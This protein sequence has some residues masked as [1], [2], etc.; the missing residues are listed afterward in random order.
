MKEITREE[1]EKELKMLE[2]IGKNFNV[3]SVDCGSINVFI[4]ECCVEIRND[5]I[6]DE[7]VIH[8]P[9]ANLEITLEW[10]GIDMICKS[11]HTSYTYTLEFNN[12]IPDI[13]ITVAG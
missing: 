11:T 10:E 2:E 1:F 6:F 5:G 12:G 4:S 7:I 3:R 9:H 13:E 8:K